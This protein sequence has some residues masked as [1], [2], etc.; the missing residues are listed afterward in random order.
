MR[1]ANKLAVHAGEAGNSV[2][3]GVVQG[4]NPEALTWQVGKKRFAKHLFQ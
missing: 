3:R 4:S 2:W 1:L